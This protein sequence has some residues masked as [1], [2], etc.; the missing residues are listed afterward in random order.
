MSVHEFA[1]RYILRVRPLT[2]NLAAVAFVLSMTGLVV[3][4]TLTPEAVAAAE[5]VAKMDP[6]TL[7]AVI[8]ILS[9]LL[10]G[11]VYK[12]AIAKLDHIA[13]VMSGLECVQQREKRLR[14][15]KLI[16]EGTK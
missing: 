7:M 1:D 15:A 12:T 4:Q 5:Q 6:T 8:A 13:A 16:L 9:I 11:Y 10:A 2:V 3:A 14:E